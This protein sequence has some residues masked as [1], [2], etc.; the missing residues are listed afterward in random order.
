MLIVAGRIE[1]ARELVDEL[2]TELRAGIEDSLREDG[3][4]FYS[5]GMEDRDL[6]HILTLQI[7]RDEAALAAHLARPELGAIV[8]KWQD[9]FVVHT[10]LYDAANE[11]MVGEWRD[12]AHERLIRESRP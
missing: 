3:C 10:R 5:F 9:R 4:R 2:F 11:R 8:G 1:T 7:W 12:P 6:G